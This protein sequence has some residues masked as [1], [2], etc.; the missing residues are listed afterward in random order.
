LD[1]NGALITDAIRHHRQRMR[2]RQS[3][4]ETELHVLVYAPDPNTLRWI[5]HE[6]FAEPIA[7]A[8]ASTIAEVVGELGRPQAPRVQMLVADFDAMTAEDVRALGQAREHWQGMAIALGTVTDELRVELAID[9]VLGRPLASEALRKAV[10][11]VSLRRAT[12]RIT[13]LER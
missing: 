5:E 12:S 1:A 3:S 11:E 13:K 10:K 4:G 9:C 2:R 7:I 8:I 6:C